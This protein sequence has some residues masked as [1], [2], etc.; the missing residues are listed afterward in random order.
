M[1]VPKKWEVMVEGVAM[2][3]LRLF[4]FFLQAALY[5]ADESSSPALHTLDN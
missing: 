3:G 1:N 5:L 2:E 4:L